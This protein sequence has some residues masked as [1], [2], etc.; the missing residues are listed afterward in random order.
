MDDDTLRVLLLV[1]VFVTGL[2]AVVARAI[3]AGIAVVLLL[4]V[5]YLLYRLLHAVE[6]LADAAARL[7]RSQGSES[8]RGSATTGGASSTDDSDDRPPVEERSTDELFE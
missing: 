1:A 5:L 7:E 2:W 8:R 3:L 4:F 6:R